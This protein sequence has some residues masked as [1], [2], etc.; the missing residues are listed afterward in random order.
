MANFA[1]SLRDLSNEI[2]I[3]L[4]TD[5]TTMTINDNSNYDD[6]APE[7]GHLRADFTAYKFVVVTDPSADVF[8][9]STLAGFDSTIAA[10][11]T[12]APSDATTY[13]IPEAGDG[14][15]Q[16]ELYTVPTWDVADTYEA[17]DDAVWNVA[18]SK[19]YKAIATTTGDQPDLSPS[20]WTAIT[21]P[22]LE[23][24]KYYTTEKV[25]RIFDLNR[26][27]ED[28]IDSVVCTVEDLFCSDDRLLKDQCFFDVQRLRVLRDGISIADSKEDYNR[29]T[30]LVNLTK[31]ICDCDC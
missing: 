8:T 12:G 22:D 17:S 26:C 5:G 29:A 3:S 14:V 10:P 9:F 16:V 6:G 1:A 15:Y 19:L 7:S 27:L 23:T 20:E 28:R 4:S 25:V 13:T 30:K 18:D 21:Q 31:Q 11:S 2:D 24:M